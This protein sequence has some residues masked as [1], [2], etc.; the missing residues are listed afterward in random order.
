MIELTE[1]ELKSYDKY[2]HDVQAEVQALRSILE[3]VQAK[4]K[5]RTWIKGKATGELDETRLVEGMTGESHIYK[6]RGKASKMHGML[7]HCFNI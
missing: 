7:L 4:N 1:Y 3:S 5:E 6:K 2:V